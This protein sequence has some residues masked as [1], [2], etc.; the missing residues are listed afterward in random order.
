MQRGLLFRLALDPGTVVGY[1]ALAE[2][3]WPDD[4]PENPK[5]SLQSLVARLRP[6][7]PAGVRRVGPGRLP[8]RDRAR[9]RRRRAIP[10]SGGRRIRRPARARRPGSPRRPSRSGRASRGRRATATTGSN[11]ARRRQGDRAT[12]RAAPRVRIRREPASAD[13]RPAHRS[14]RPHRGTRRGR[15]SSRAIP[16][17][18]DHR[19]GGA[20]KTRIAVEV[21]RRT[22][23]AV[24]VELAP[25]TAGRALGRAASAPSG[26]RCAPPTGRPSTQQP[27]RA[28][29]SRPR[30]ARC[31]AGARQLRARRRGGRRAV[32]TSCSPRCRACASWPPAASR[33]ASRARR[34]CRSAR[35]P[36]PTPNA[37]SPSACSPLAAPLTDRGR[38][39][40]GGR[41]GA[42][43]PRRPAARPR[44]GR[45]P[46][47][48]AR[49]SPSSP[50]A[51]TTASRCSR[52]DR[53]RRCRGI[54][55]CAP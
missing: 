27:A 35:S 18:H 36:T 20:G 30:R 50:P 32:P 7:L 47:P 13:P 28:G 21:A 46:H 16:A 42:R 11:G 51:S 38:R 10:G 19:P 17:D 24:L 6:Q 31:P 25:V 1:R 26:A 43:A 34:S 14:H 29:A 12:A 9:R 49:R 48:H 15:R 23:G 53:A 39:R 33:W 54:R 40:A 41:P 45:G 22:A 2:D 3:L 52:P 4:L 8:P 44:A 37:S 5:A 55:P